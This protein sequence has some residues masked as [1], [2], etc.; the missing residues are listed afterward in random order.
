MSWDKNKKIK[1]LFFSP[2]A[3]RRNLK[4]KNKANNEM[5]TQIRRRPSSEIYKIVNNWAGIFFLRKKKG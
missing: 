5:E 2:K 1:N 4:K 3:T